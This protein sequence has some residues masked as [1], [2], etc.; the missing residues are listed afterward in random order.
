VCYENEADLFLF[1][2]S[3]VELSRCRTNVSEQTHIMANIAGY[4]TIIEPRNHKWSGQ[5]YVLVE[6]MLFQKLDCIILNKVQRGETSLKAS[7]D[8]RN[9]AL[10]PSERGRIGQKT[11]YIL[12]YLGMGVDAEL[13]IGEISG[14]LPKAGNCKAWYDYLIKLIL[15][16]RDCLLRLQDHWGNDD[17]RVFYF[18]QVHGKYGKVKLT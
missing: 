4:F 15:G 3:N 18:F 2:L 14:G 5:W 12:N 17:D 6:V 10:D 16:A 1:F 11:D 8:R 7:A 13:F 9:R